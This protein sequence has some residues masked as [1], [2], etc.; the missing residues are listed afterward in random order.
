V[1]MNAE[2]SSVECRGARSAPDLA[3]IEQTMSQFLSILDKLG[4]SADGARFDLVANGYFTPGGSAKE[5]LRQFAPTFL[6]VSIHNG[7]SVEAPLESGTLVHVQ[8]E[9]AFANDLQVSI[10]IQVREKD[11]D[12]FNRLLTSNFPADLFTVL[13]CLNVEVKIPPYE[14]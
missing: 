7:I 14:A 10:H 13:K 8:M 2:T 11:R 3:I 9:R 4:L 12:E 1:E 6:P 5:W